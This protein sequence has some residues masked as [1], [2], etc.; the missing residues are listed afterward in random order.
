MNPFTGVLWLLHGK[1]TS[2]NRVN[3]SV[4]ARC[5]P[6]NTVNTAPRAKH[7]VNTVIFGLQGTKTIPKAFKNWPN[8]ATLTPLGALCA[9]SPSPTTAATESIR[10]WIF[11]FIFFEMLAWRR[12][13]HREASTNR[14]RYAQQPLHR[15][16]LSAHI[17]LHR[18]VCAERSL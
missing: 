5:C 14:R 16:A 7:F 17:L 2:C 11:C 8:I 6:N 10:A 18:E 13:L 1:N 15:A 9:S 12:I 3:A 4:S